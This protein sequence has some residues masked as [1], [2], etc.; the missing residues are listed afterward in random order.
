MANANTH[1][2]EGFLRFRTW[3]IK[4]MI[5]WILL[6][7]DMNDYQLL[8]KPCLLGKCGRLIIR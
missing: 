6:S 4:V 7:I 5:S 2:L 8:K 1:N 3:N